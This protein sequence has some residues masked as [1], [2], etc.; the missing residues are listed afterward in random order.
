M[1]QVATLGFS[2]FNISYK[3]K[4]MK[5]ITHFGKKLLFENIF[6]NAIFDKFYFEPFGNNF[7][8]S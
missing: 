1:L 7:L 2:I 5:Y 4:L 3:S 6:K 8:W